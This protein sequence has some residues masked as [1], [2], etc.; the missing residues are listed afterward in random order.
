MC[1]S[2]QALKPDLERLVVFDED[3]NDVL[4]SA[5]GGRRDRLRADGLFV[6]IATGIVTG[7]VLVAAQ[8]FGHASADFLY[9][10]ATA[11]GVA[12]LSLG[13]LFWPSKAKELVW[14]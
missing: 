13:R 5:H 9:G 11:L 1:Q 4:A 3:S 14:R 8:A 6:P 2:G 12:I 10:S 7:V